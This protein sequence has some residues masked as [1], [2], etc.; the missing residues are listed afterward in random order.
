[1][2]VKKL[3]MGTAGMRGK[4]GIGQDKLNFAYI[5]QIVNAF[6]LYLINKYSNVKEKIVIIGRDNRNL[7]KEF[8]YYSAQILS[9]YNIKVKLSKDICPT[10]FVSYC[11][12]KF[13]ALGGINITASHNPKEYN[14]IKLYNSF[15]G[16]CL[17]EEVENIK[18]YF[19]PYNNSKETLNIDCKLINNVEYI[20]E[21]L[22]QKYCNKIIEKLNFNSPINN[23]KIVYSPLHGTGLK[24]VK[25][26]ST[27]IFL[28]SNNLFFEPFQSKEDKDFS[29]CPSPNPE[30]NETYKWAELYNDKQNIDADAIILTDPDSDRIGIKIKHKN[31]YVLLN[32]NEIATLIFYFL[33]INKVNIKNNYLSYSF[34]S[35]NLPAKIA[36][37]KNI[38]TFEVP[39]GFKWI[40]HIINQNKNNNFLFAFEE[41]N[42]CLLDSS[43]S[44]DKDAIQ[45]FVILIKMLSFYKDK[46][47]T[48]YDVLQ[49]I[50]LKYGFLKTK[51]ISFDI[52]NKT[53]KQ[54]NLIIN[55]FKNL[56]FENANFID[57]NLKNDI[58]KSN[59]YR[60]LF[61]DDSWISLRPSGTEPKIKIYISTYGNTELEAENKL[62]WM[63]N[64]IDNLLK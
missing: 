43:I 30:Y 23:I 39:T 19:S 11:I 27:K 2:L 50:Y 9:K 16:Q 22:Y 48:L 34:V 24:Y 12:M 36:K 63:S 37:Q 64:K 20:E 47:L 54:V 10:P 7:S 44:R 49:N 26:L 25:Y 18:K 55:N 62:I 17:P 46:N 41:S 61:N 28:N 3:E 60:Y 33:T 8:A 15:G 52:T 6:G 35:S 32:G 58:L 56:N 4:V 57:F 13:N 51:T 45:A 14:G 21:N 31:Q 40:T 5:D 53:K 42:G 59:M 29:Y 1:M 38:K